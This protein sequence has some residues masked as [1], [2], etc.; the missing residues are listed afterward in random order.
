MLKMIILMI[1]NLVQ[2]N[3]IIYL[4]NIILIKALL[5]KIANLIIIIFVSLTKNIEKIY[6]INIVYFQIKKFKLSNNFDEKHSKKFL[7]KKDKCLER[8]IISDEIENNN[9][10]LDLKKKKFSTQKNIHN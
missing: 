2:I 1:M 6:S 3:K 9:K 7:V 5:T 8:I 4:K 10:D